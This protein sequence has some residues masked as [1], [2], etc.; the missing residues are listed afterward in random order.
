MYST[1]S[2]D[3]EVRVFEDVEELSSGLAEYVHRVSEEAVSDRGSFSLV[4]SGGDIP[5]LLR[6]LGSLP[7]VRTAEWSRWHVFWAEENLVPKRH[8]DSFYMQAK[9]SFISKVPIPPAHIIPVPHGVPGDA[10]ANAYEYSIRQLIRT[11]TVPASPSTDCPRF[12][13]VILRLGPDGSISSFYFGHS[14]PDEDSQWV[15]AVSSPNTPLERVALTLPVVN[16]AS[17]VVVVA[18]GSDAARTF[19]EAVAGRRINEDGSHPAHLIRPID[20]K[21][22]WFADA[23]AA[24]LLSMHQHGGL[25]GTR[26]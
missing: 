9:H 17:N 7:Y 3:P 26:A 5:H 14:V 24:G 19:C 2:L 16:A 8:P 23:A 21:L 25:S 18:S 4:L 22:I 6:K 13:L 20:G 11:R 1:W 15:T 12:D 10:A